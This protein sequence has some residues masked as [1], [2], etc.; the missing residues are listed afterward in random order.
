MDDYRRSPATPH[1]K[2]TKQAGRCSVCRALQNRS[3]A[4]E[5][6]ATV[7]EESSIMDSIDSVRPKKRGNTGRSRFDR[8]RARAS[9]VNFRADKSISRG[10]RGVYQGTS[11][12][13]LSSIR[14]IGGRLVQ[15]LDCKPKRS[16]KYIEKVQRL[17]APFR[18]DFLK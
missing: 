9:A 6:G 4:D 1:S 2:N 10:Q 15:I 7:T 18:I 13:Q 5:N 8:S 12:I 17:A 16:T 11:E 14:I 3:F